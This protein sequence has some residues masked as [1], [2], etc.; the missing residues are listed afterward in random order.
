M[1]NMFFNVYGG[2]DRL[3]PR[4]RNDAQQRRYRNELL[5]SLT[6]AAHHLREAETGQEEFQYKVKRAGAEA[7]CEVQK[8]TEER[9]L[10]N[11]AGA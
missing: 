10:Q 2:E 1:L 6:Q 4:A 7:V 9:A 8:Q 3:R 5:Q 11:A